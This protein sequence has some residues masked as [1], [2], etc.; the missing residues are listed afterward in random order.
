MERYGDLAA[1]VVND[2]MFARADMEED[3]DEDE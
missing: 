1:T 2:T 3:C